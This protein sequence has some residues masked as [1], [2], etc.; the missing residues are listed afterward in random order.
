MREILWLMLA[1]AVALPADN[2]L[3][4][5]E[6]MGGWRLLFDGQT[7]R[8][9][10]D[11]ARESAPADAWLIEDGC[12]K[13]RLHP[14]IAEDLVTEE[15]FGDFEMTFDWRVSP[16]GNTGVKYR[17]Q[18]LIFVDNT[19]VQQGPG[20]FEGMIA[21][22][23]ANPLSDRARLAR[24]ATAQQYSVAFEMQLLDD[25]RHPDA[26]SG[27]RYRTGALYGM[28]AP[29]ASPANPA[30]AWNTGRIIVRGDRIEH[31]LNGVKVLEGS[32]SAEEVREGAAKRWGRYPAILRMLTSPKPSGPLCLQ[33][34]GSEAAFRN[35]K[36][37]RL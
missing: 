31:W 30:G 29:A 21:R 9:W 13:T 26:R 19:K 22:E 34:H 7:M 17:I 33:H 12:L 20:G 35:L 25:G 11:P 2:I 5:Q 36:I 6:K 27:P 23:A 10:R 32:L 8:G 1:A 3:T 14:R 16:G 4:P 15:S 28:I 24:E 37:R 18:S